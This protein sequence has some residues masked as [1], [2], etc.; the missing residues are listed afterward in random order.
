MQKIHIGELIKTE[1]QR[2][3]RSASWL[4]NKINCNRTN[5]YKIFL[6][7]SIDTEL[8]FIISNALNHNFFK[9]Y[10]INLPCCDKMNTKV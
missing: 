9:Y 10:T 6:R 3:E 1:L 4:A 7:Q 2:Q 8:L 5:I